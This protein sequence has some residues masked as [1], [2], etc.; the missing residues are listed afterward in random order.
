MRTKT[1]ALCMAGTILTFLFVWEQVQATRLGYRVS[2]RRVELGRRRDRTAYLRLELARLRAPARL[3]EEAARLLDMAPA[4]PER[5][6]FLTSRVPRFQL[7]VTRP[8]GE[9]PSSNS[10]W[11][12]SPKTAQGPPDGRMAALI[13]G[14]AR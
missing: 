1:I 7:T 3:A 2:R 4:E 6:V 12:R 8:A 11:K 9:K 14:T 10:V 13:G 5:L